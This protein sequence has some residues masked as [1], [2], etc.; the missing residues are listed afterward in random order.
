VA[1][2]DG[3]WRLHLDGVPDVTTD[4]LTLDDVE[5]AERV[6]DVPYP[7]LNP[8]ASARQA[9]ALL[10]VLLVRAGRSEDEAL[11]TA[12]RTPLR[13]ISQAFTWVPPDRP[14]RAVSDGTTDPPSSAP[15][16]VAG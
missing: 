16:S 3:C 14:L 8:L 1:G 4:E 6:C 9:K 7:L 2:S 5:I 15:T 13:V 12:S 11:E 10:T